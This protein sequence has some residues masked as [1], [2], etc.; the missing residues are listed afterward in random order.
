MADTGQLVGDLHLAA[1]VMNVQDMNRA[2]DFRTAAPRLRA[3]RAE[4]GSTVHDAGRPRPAA[5]SQVSLQLTDSLP[6]EQ[7]RVHLDLYTSKQA[8][9]VERLVKLGATRV[10]KWPY[11]DGGLHR[12]ADPDDNEFCVIDHPEL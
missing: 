10:D 12:H 4:L 5:D 8:R 7:V 3:P 1:V 11:P 2:V 9:H 6:R